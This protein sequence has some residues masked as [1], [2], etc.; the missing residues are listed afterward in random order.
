MGEGQAHLQSSSWKF[1]ATHRWRGD[2]SVSNLRCVAE[3][4]SK[5]RQVTKV[6]ITLHTTIVTTIEIERIDII[7]LNVHHIVVDVIVVM[8]DFQKGLEVEVTVMNIREE[9]IL[10]KEVEVEVLKDMQKGIL[11]LL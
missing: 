1:E 11:S 9:N 5:W 2:E 6:A 10:K 4:C 7:I 3:S 8:I